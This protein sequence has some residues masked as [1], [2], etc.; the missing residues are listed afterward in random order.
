MTTLQVNIHAAKSRLSELLREVEAGT[1]VIVARA[2]QPVAKLIPWP[3][4]PPE[5]KFGF[6]E[7]Q[8]HIYE[9][10]IVSSDPEIVAMFEESAERDLYQP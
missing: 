5:R 1:D 10:D 3:P 8:I 9:D 6:L 2:G 4:K 7:G